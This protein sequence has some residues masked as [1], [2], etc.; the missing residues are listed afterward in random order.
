[1]IHIFES[2]GRPHEAAALAAMFEARKRVFVDLLSWNVPVVENRYEIDQFDDRHARYVVLTAPD[3]AHM[4][5]A[6]LLPTTRPH[7]LGSLYSDLCDGNVPCGPSIVEISRF[8]IDRQLRAA[9]RKLARNRLVSALVDDAL[10]SGVRIYTAVAEH[11]WQQ[12]ILQFGWVCRSLGRPR[13]VDGKLTGA[14]AI[15]ISAD[16]PV[17]LARGGIYT[18]SSVVAETRH[19][20]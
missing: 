2:G 11:A 8:C 20:A 4:A 12:Q 10:E 7:I 14:V 17:H 15:E 18:H 16:T 6:R 9:E 3:G 13:L 19:A 1:M 5:S